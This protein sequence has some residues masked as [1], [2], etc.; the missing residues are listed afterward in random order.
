MRVVGGAGAGSW[1]AVYSIFVEVHCQNKNFRNDN[2][3]YSNGTGIICNAMRPFLYV[4]IL[5]GYLFNTSFFSTVADPDSVGSN[6]PD[7]DP[8]SKMY[9]KRGRGNRYL[10][11]LGVGFGGA[12][13]VS[14]KSRGLR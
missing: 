11:E 8:G 12:R 6:H 13:E 5:T 7:Q 1:L 4:L 10:E 2:Y 14:L 9:P 3:I